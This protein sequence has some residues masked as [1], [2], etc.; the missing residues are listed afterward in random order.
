[1]E[2]KTNRKTYINRLKSAVFS[3]FLVIGIVIDILSICWCQVECFLSQFIASIRY[4]NH[5]VEPLLF[6]QIYSILIVISSYLLTVWA[7]ISELTIRSWVAV[8]KILNFVLFA[9]TALTIE[10]YVLLTFYGNNRLAPWCWW[11]TF[12]YAS[13]WKADFIST[14]ML[15]DS[16]HARCG[17]HTSK[18]PHVFCSIDRTCSVSSWAPLSEHC[19]NYCS[20]VKLE[21]LFSF[22]KE[23]IRKFHWLVKC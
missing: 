7:P 13:V 9:N 16:L 2:I 5:D 18:R 23:I 8:P 21:S 12:T 4:K 14:K 17:L 22:R 19:R 1:M 15:E 3:S 10:H 6:T 11:F 20:R